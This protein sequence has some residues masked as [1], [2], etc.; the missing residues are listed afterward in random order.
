MSLN[1]LAP[2]FLPSYQSSSNPPISLCNSTTM[3]L[4]LAQLICGMSPQTFPS[5]VPSIN[6]HFADNTLILPLLQPTNQSKPDA[7]VPQPT[8]GPS[9]FMPS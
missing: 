7:A 3:G 6:Q 2:A 5:Y 1:P 9:A 8:P 4:L